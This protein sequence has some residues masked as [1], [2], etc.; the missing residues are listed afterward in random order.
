MLLQI[1]KLQLAVLEVLDEL[2]IPLP[3]GSARGTAIDPVAVVVGV[4]PVEGL[5]VP[6]PLLSEEWD[7]AKTIDDL[8]GLKRPPG[9]LEDRRIEVHAGDRHVAYIPRL[10]HS[11]PA[12]DQRNSDPPLVD[13]SLPLP[14]GRV[15]RRRFGAA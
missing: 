4:V 6:G 7:Q 14:E 15:G 10:R 2:E 11:G 9:R 5:S 8:M 1:V 3:Y 12:D 13:R